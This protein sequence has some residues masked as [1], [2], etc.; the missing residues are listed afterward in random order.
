MLNYAEKELCRIARIC[1]QEKK[2]LLDLKTYHRC[3]AGVATA[4][5]TDAFFQ[6]RADI[7]K[8]YT[9]PTYFCDDYIVDGSFECEGEGCMQL[10]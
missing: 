8:Y 5:F 4:V 9:D 7:R 10:N 6:N 3:F 2:S 1:N